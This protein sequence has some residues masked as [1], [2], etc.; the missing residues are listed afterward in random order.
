MSN[1]IIPDSH[2]VLFEK[3]IPASLATVMADGLV[4]VNP[5]WVE[6]DGTFICFNSAQGR[7]KDKNLKQRRVATLLLV[8]PENPYF[9]IEIR[10]RVA[11]ITTEG[12]NQQIDRLAKKYLGQDKYPWRRE[13]EVRISYKIKPER[14][15]AFSPQG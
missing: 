14:V 2:R 10:G 6:Y 3:P 1:L 5:V 11:E 13:G 15:N 4:Q 9:W 12:A 8:D 7:Q